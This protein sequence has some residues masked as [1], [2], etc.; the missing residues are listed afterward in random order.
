[1][2]DVARLNWGC[3]ADPAPG[4]INADRIDKP[5]IDIVRD[6]REGLPLEDDSIDY[7]TSQHALQEV[8]FPDLVPVLGELRRVLRPG[9]VLRLVVPDADRAI[10]A[11]LEGDRSYFAVPDEDARTIGGKFVAHILWYSHS[12]VMFTF[13]FMEELL[14]RAGFQPAVRSSFRETTSDFADI[15]ELD[16]RE[17][18][19]VFVEARK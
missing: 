3:G 13:D 12:R 17:E 18:E 9:G 2:S 8:P 14:Q 6:I 15:V 1:M 19:S 11:Y 4:W 7:I 10:R 16:D 5:G